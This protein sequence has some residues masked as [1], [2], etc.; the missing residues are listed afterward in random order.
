MKEKIAVL[1]PKGTFTENAARK[2][3]K[4]PSLVYMDDAIDVFRFVD[5]GK[6]K[7][8][9][10]I[11]NSLEG[12]VSKNMEGLMEYD[13]KIC[14]EATLDINLCLMKNKN[15]NQ[16]RRI[17]SHPHA[18][19]QCKNYLRRRYPEAMLQASDSTSAAMQQLRKTI[20]SAAI[21]PKESAKIYGL[22]I[23]AKNIQ[24]DKSQTRFI[25]ISKKEGCFSR[26]K[27]KTSLIYAVKDKPGALFNT[28]K[29]FAD[30]KVNLTKIESRP[31]RRKLGEYIFYIDFE[32][33]G[34][35]SEGVKRILQ[36]IRKETSF[37]KNLG[38]Y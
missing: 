38:S 6:G 18:L 22:Q 20:N 23:L 34:L 13:V 3:F 37:L 9:I 24:D 7:G 31:S 27:G 28:M 32:N 16:V 35:G 1:G 10:A 12:S 30:N 17:I 5:R 29:I 14:G 36:K 8:V 19:A 4:N 25:A 11:E 26:K 21:G 33:K 2:L 15:G